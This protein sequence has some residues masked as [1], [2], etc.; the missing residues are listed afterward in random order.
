MNKDRSVWMTLVMIVVYSTYFH[1]I[2]QLYFLFFCLCL[3]S[4]KDGRRKLEPYRELLISVQKLTDLFWIYQAE[5][6]IIKG[7]F[8]VLWS[9]YLPDVYVLVVLI[10]Y[11][12]LHTSL[13]LKS[14]DILYLTRQ[15]FTCQN[16]M[17]LK[18][19]VKPCNFPVNMYYFN[20]LR[21][22]L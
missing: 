11:I 2:S 1:S 12:S 22:S 15:N 3:H 14:V 5:C 8:S 18:F 20:I 17:I 7:W 10:L 6:N 19:C 9:N 16:T 21:S 13:H 4:Y